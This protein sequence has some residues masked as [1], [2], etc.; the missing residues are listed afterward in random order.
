MTVRRQQ[1]IFRKL[2]ALCIGNIIASD[3]KENN[4]KLIVFSP[5]PFISMKGIFLLWKRLEKAVYYNQY[6][7]I[8]LLINSENELN[9]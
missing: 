5:M 6:Y 2:Q 1:E 4:H 7:Y 8:I 9:K 3:G